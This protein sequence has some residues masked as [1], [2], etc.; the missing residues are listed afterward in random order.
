MPHSPSEILPKINAT[1]KVHPYTTQAGSIIL[2][3]NVTS[4]Y[5][6]YKLL[7]NILMPVFFHYGYHHF[8]NVFN[9]FSQ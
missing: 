9:L 7:G 3:F 4:M 5:F 8:L 1:Y 2:L 6:I